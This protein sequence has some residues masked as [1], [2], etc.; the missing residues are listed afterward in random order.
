MVEQACATEA[1]A[2]ST[3]MDQLLAKIR[4]VTDIPKP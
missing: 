4:E 2:C 3:V 1:Q